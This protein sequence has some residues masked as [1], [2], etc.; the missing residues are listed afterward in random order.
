M[1]RVRIELEWSLDADLNPPA[2]S[3]AQHLNV[4]LA[5]TQHCSRVTVHVLP[6]HSSLKESYSERAS[7]GYV[8]LDWTPEQEARIEPFEVLLEDD[9]L[10]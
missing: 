10:V 8:P 6:D 1:S 9:P 3:V 2:Q 7:R 5:N 4:W